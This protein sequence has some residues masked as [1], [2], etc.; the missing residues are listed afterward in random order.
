[1]LLSLPSVL[2]FVFSCY[3]LCSLSLF[4]SFSAIFLVL[5]LFL[6][7]STRF[8][9]LRPVH[10]PCKMSK[11]SPQCHY[12]SSIFHRIHCSRSCM[13]MLFVICWLVARIY[14]TRASILKFTS[15]RN[16][17]EIVIVHRMYKI[18]IFVY[19]ALSGSLSRNGVSLIRRGVVFLENCLHFRYIWFNVYKFCVYLSHLLWFSSSGN[20]SRCY[21]QWQITRD[22]PSIFVF[23]RVYLA[24]CFTFFLFRVVIFVCPGRCLLYSDGGSVG[25]G[26]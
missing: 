11:L 15:D 2:F 16:H 6:C 14:F 22:L 1:M 9:D 5:C 4:S 25:G 24:V 21:S 8:F 18:Y 13:C 10:R 17:Y 20:K 12:L 19:Y 7:C 23:F 3:F 26:G